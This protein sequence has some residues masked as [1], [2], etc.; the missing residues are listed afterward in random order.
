M[1]SIAFGV[2][3]DIQNGKG[4]KIYKAAGDMFSPGEGADVMWI[5][6]VAG[7]NTSPFAEV[8]WTYIYCECKKKL[9]GG[10]IFAIFIGTIT[11]RKY[12]LRIVHHVVL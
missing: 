12:S 1:L 11:P 8:T 6:L 7:E 9:H 10:N 5:L 2:S 4:G 3:L